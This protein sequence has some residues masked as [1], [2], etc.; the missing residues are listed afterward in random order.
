M[1]GQASTAA[2]LLG[3]RGGGG[4]GGGGQNAA[5]A[6]LPAPDCW[7][8][9]SN[10]DADVDLVVSVGEDAYV[11]VDK[12]PITDTHA[13]V[14]PVEHVPSTVALSASAAA[15][16]SCPAADEV[17]AYLR[18]LRALCAARGLALF[19]FERY[20]A[21][22]KGAGGN[23]AQVHALGVPAAC[24]PTARATIEALAAEAG[25]TGLVH[26]PGDPLAG[27]PARAALR[28]AVGDG[29][30]FQAWLPWDGV[31]GPCPGRLVQPVP[32][33]ARHP[34][35]FG[36][37]VAAALAGCPERADWKECAVAPPQEVERA[38]AFKAAFAPHDPTLAGEGVEAVVDADADAAPAA[39]ADAAP[40]AACE[41]DGGA[42]APT[43]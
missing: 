35:A 42:P 1:A 23:H 16:P 41:G 32:K 24:V 31:A 2:S 12:G 20:A 14:L 4:G 38:E 6:A 5:Q 19:A 13:L 25:I 9:L 15:S 39:D 27:P 43:A 37:A 7:F 36:R 26:L 8:C 28:D 18:G 33:G 11:A 3:A 34:L 17:E 10:P 29:E 22:R 30:F 40:A 21:L